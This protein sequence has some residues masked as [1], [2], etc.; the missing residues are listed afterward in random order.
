MNRARIDDWTAAGAKTL[1]QRTMEMTK[2]ILAMAEP[3]A[4]PAETVAALKDIV[5]KAEAKM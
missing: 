1:G 5:A 2:S 4:L 3:E